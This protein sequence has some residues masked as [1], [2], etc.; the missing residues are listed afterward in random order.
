M[1]LF[2]KPEFQSRVMLDGEDDCDNCQHQTDLVCSAVR[3]FRTCTNVHPCEYFNKVHHQARSEKP[4]LVEQPHY[5]N[6][7]AERTALYVR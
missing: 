1:Y 5:G 7:A 4:W 2:A 3:V 6:D